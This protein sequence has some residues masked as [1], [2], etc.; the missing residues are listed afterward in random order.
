MQKCNYKLLNRC[1]VLKLSIVLG[2]N[3]LTKSCKEMFEKSYRARTGS[4]LKTCESSLFSINKTWIRSNRVTLTLLFSHLLGNDLMQVSQQFIKPQL[5][6]WNGYETLQTPLLYVFVNL[7]VHNV[8]E[9]SQH[10]DLI[11]QQKRCIN[12]FHHNLP[13]RT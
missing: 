1:N 12:L 13:N 6:D 4:L 8:Q 3:K 11:D 10:F 5:T 2:Y 7:M 9:H